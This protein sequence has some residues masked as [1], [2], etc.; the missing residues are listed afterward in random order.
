MSRK[1]K[2][3]AWHK[4]NKTMLRNP[5]FVITNGLLE[6]M[7]CEIMQFTGLTDIKG[8]DIY[9]G[10]IVKTT[11]THGDTVSVGSVQ[12]SHGVFGAEWTR[13]ITNKAMVGTFGQLHNLKSLDDHI[14]DRLEVIGNIYEN[15]EL[16]K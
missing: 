4:K 12:F 1:M 16:L 15:S 11:T 3:R 2:F 14:I 9:E 13:N 6:S 8:K 10:D 5:T 7:E